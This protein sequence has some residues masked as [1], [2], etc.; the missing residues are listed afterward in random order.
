MR[1]RLVVPGNRLKTEFTPQVEKMRNH[2][3]FEARHHVGQF[4]GKVHLE[5]SGYEE[6]EDRTPARPN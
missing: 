5:T 4:R 2:S 1:A 6:S 3:L